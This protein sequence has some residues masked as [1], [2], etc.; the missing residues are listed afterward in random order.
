MLLWDSLFPT[1]YFDICRVQEK[2]NYI[3]WVFI[4]ELSLL[5]IILSF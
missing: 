5:A 4:I 2:K 1:K 3:Y